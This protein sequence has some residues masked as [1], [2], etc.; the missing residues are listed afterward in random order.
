MPMC[1]AWSET[2]SRLKQQYADARIVIPG[3]GKSG[4]TELFDYTINLFK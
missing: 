2:V 3:H 1:N 4:G